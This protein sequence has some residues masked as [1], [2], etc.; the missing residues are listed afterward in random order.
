M[1]IFP[2]F[3]VGE[4]WGGLMGMDLSKAIRKRENVFYCLTCIT[5]DKRGAQN[6]VWF[7]VRHRKCHSKDHFRSSLAWQ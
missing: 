1:E 5:N 6:Q 3:W 4:G 7:D 2:L